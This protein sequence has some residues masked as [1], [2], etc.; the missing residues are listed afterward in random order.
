M[1]VLA[2]RRAVGLA[3]KRSDPKTPVDV[4]R[5]AACGYFGIFGAGADLWHRRGDVQCGI[6]VQTSTSEALYGDVLLGLREPR[7]V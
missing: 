3:A 2:I 7:G 1:L 4:V 5:G 6:P